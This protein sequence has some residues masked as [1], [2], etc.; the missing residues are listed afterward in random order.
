MKKLLLLMLLPLAGC[1]S[2]NDAL[3]GDENT[4]GLGTHSYS[5]LPDGTV[6]I[7]VHSIY[8][9]PGLEVIQEDGKVTTT[10]IPADRIKLEIIKDLIP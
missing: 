3:K 9:G 8:G 5:V 1:A 10:V 4:P 7:D 2:F 6:Q